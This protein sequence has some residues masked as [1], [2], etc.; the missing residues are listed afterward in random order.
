MTAGGLYR[1]SLLCKYM[2]IQWLFIMPNLEILGLLL[3]LLL[4]SATVQLCKGRF[5]NPID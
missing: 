5:T 2:P 4:S 1:L 3:S